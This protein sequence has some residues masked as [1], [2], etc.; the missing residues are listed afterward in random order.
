MSDSSTNPFPSVVC[1]DADVSCGSVA[2]IGGLDLTVGRYDDQNHSLFQSMANQHA[3]DFYQVDFM[4][5]HG[6]ND[7]LL[8][9]HI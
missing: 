2:Y 5:N 1:D 3:D 7:F 8:V 9:F 4:K 6:L